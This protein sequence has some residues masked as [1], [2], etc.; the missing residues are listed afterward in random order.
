MIVRGIFRTVVFLAFLWGGWYAIAALADLYMVLVVCAGCYGYAVF[1]DGVVF[2]TFLSLLLM[3]VAVA[4]RLFPKP[5]RYAHFLFWIGVFALPGFL[6]VMD[7]AEAGRPFIPEI[8]FFSL[9]IVFHWA[10][11]C[12]AQWAGGIKPRTPEWELS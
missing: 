3:P 9:M 4:L 5:W 7:E 8:F 2:Y 1:I 12:V 6:W 10:A 11:A